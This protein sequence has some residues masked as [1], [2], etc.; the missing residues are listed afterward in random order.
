MRT[1]AA[2]VLILWGVSG[3]ASSD[4]DQIRERV[5]SVPAYQFE[6]YDFDADRPLHRRVGAMPAHVLEYVRALDERPDY[7]SYQPTAAE[8]RLIRRS[9]DRLPPRLKQN[10][11]RRGLGIYFIDDF[12]TSGLTDWA[13]SGDPK[14]ESP[15]EIYSYMVFHA[16]SLKTSMQD[17]LNER[18]ASCFR[19]DDSGTE[20]EIRLG[21]K[22]SAFTYLLLHEAVHALDYSER[23]SPY[24][25]ESVYPYQR[26]IQR[27]IQAGELIDRVWSD[28]REPRAAFDFPTRKLVTFYGFRGG[29]RL[30][31]GEASE[32]YRGL[33]GSPFVSLYGSQMW[34]EDLAELVSMYYLTEAAGRSYSIRLKRKG[35]IIA[36]HEP[37]KF[38]AVRERLRDLRRHFDS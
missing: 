15:P 13:V 9:L 2:G 35:R 37:L 7:K 1:A 31:L 20:I 22:E 38:P 16:K 26:R 4:V 25:E 3:C 10:L 27:D 8:M 32:V 5:Q 6:R 12:L 23:I 34:P 24:V 36:E 19:K 21:G 14:G 30:A 11:E 28:Y 18:E 33:A 17:L 29:P